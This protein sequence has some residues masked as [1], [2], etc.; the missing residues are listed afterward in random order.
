MCA[1]N[2]GKEHSAP[3]T[4]YKPLDN[5]IMLLYPMNVVYCGLT[6]TC[7][8]TIAIY[9]CNIGRM[10]QLIRLK[11]GLFLQSVYNVSITINPV[12]VKLS[13]SV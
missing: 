11:F 2:E 12:V 13:V 1:M 6:Y 7:L 8:Y 3:L 4:K 10:N 9:L 5:N